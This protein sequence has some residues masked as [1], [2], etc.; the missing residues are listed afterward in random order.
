MPPRRAPLIGREHLLASLRQAV[1]DSRAGHPGVVL[2][3]GEAGI[4]KTRLLAE[5]VAEL[6]ERPAAE[7]PLVLRGSCCTADRS[8]VPW[9]PFL[10]VLRDVRQ[11]LGTEEFL[12]LAGRRA[13]ELSLLDPGIPVEHP[14]VAPTEGRLLRVLSGL[15]LDVASD[16]PTLLVIEDLQWAD[17]GSHRV[18]EYVVRSLRRQPLTVVVTVR[19]GE[20]GRHDVPAAVEELE[21]AGHVARLQPSRLDRDQVALQLA[22]LCGAAPDPEVL[23]QVVELSAGLPLYVE[24]LAAVLQADG[25]L[26]QMSSRLHGH[27]L[28]GL[29]SDALA[30]VETTALAAMPP[31]ADHVLAASALP[32]PAF[33]AALAQAVDA[34]VLSRR[35]SLLEFRHAVLREATLERLLPHREQDLH[36]RW[37]DVLQ[38]EADGL[39]IAVTVAHHRMAAGE[40]S[41]ALT[42][43][44]LAADAAGRASGFSVQLEMLQ[45][46]VR[47]WPQ[48]DDAEELAGR[49]LVEVLAQAAEAAFFASADAALTRG[50]AARAVRLLPADAAPARRA[51]L[52]LLVLRCRYSQAEPIAVSELLEVVQAIPSE[53][54]TRERV[55]ACVMTAGQLLQAGR[56]DEADLYAREGAR[57]AHGL[58]LAQLEADAT[59]AEAL[60]HVHRG[61][62]DDAVRS[63]VRARLLADATGDPFARADAW[64]VMGLVMWHVGDTVAAVESCRNA[65]EL[66][67]GP[68]PGPDVRRWAMNLTNLA[69]G[70]IEQGDWAEAQQALDRVLAVPHLRGRE[71]DFACR[72]SR[73]LRLW[74]DGP[75]PDYVACDVPVDPDADFDTVGIQ[76]LVPGRYTDADISSQHHHLV[77]ARAE[78]RAPLADVRSAQLP[79]ALYNL[80]GVAARTEADARREHWP[81]PD[82]DAGE[83]TVGRVRVLL[84]MMTPAGPVPVAQDAHARADLDRWAGED[85]P[86]IWAHVVTLWRRVSHPRPLAVALLQLGSAEAV[87]GDRH[88]A[89]A[90]LGEALQISERLGARPLSAAARQLASRHNLRIVTPPRRSG[91]PT[92]LTVR[93][94][95]VLRLLAE[96]ASNGEIGDQL[97]ISGRTASVH[98]SHILDKLGVTSRTAAATVAHKAGLLLPQPEGG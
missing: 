92:A 48:V 1:A 71:T 25:D 79:E 76:D 77:R 66:V 29:S 57:S 65:V 41:T 94:L 83:W 27:R 42:A 47:L 36:R 80:L 87:S 55:V 24:E 5:F 43:S 17:E 62:Y 37:A 6:E 10:D 51:W 4:G 26:S 60:L 8:D 68:R 54:P 53:P 59:S 21:R 13:L 45:E 84:D 19:T 44:V 31:R 69:E 64:Q 82:P 15:L 52:E 93:E 89:R 34:G 16:R 95:E 96:G 38:P 23:D 86:A 61:R 9:G 73:H 2:I 46:V 97:F 18:L 78:L 50:F 74:R 40:R 32:G 14:P 85:D 58:G 63:A 75:D 88:A 3:A 81:D 35:G 70:L 49:D 30:V 28:A 56:P 7:G 91:G 67:G 12:S 39:E 33:D 22:F 20:T 90:D 72:L 98:V 11:S